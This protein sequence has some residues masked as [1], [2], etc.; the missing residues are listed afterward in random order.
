MRRSSMK[1]KVMNI[2]VLIALLTFALAPEAGGWGEGRAPVDIDRNI[3]KHIESLV[4]IGPRQAGTLN[5]GRAADYIA[6]QFRAMGIPVLIE[7]FAFESFEPSGVE[8]R[9]G[10]EK[11]APAGLGLDPY[12]GE[13][14]YEGAFVLLDPLTPFSW[15]SSEAV[16]GKAVVTAEEG[17]PSLHFRITALGPRFIIDLSPGDFD[18]IRE[19]KESELTLSVRGEL[20]KGTS[21][22]VIAHL[23]P[24]PP[25]V[26]III[27]AHLDAYRDCPGASDNASGV[28]ALLELARYMK[29]FENLERIG[30][31][32][33]AFGA[34]EVGILGSRRYVERHGDEL[35]HCS[36]A[37][38]IDDLGGGAPVHIERNGGQQALP[39]NPGV[40]LIPQTYQG[41][42]WEG[43][44][45]PWKLMPPPTL[46]AALG[47]SF[48]P[49]WLVDSI[50]KAVKELGIEVHFTQIQGSDQMSFAQAGIATSGITAPTGRGHT[51]DDRPDTVNIEK[52]RQ[53]VETAGRILLR[54]LDHLRPPSPDEPIGL[55]PGHE[56]LAHVRFLASDEL[57]GRRAG[58]PEG[59]IAA[60]YIAEHL[61]A[62]GVEAF[63]DAPEYFQDVVWQRKDG[64][65]GPAGDPVHAHNV[66][67]FIRG[68][69]ASRA[70]EYVLLMAH[71]D[72]LGA[73]SVDNV[74]TI[75]NGARDNAMG[76]AAVLTAAESLAA[77]PPARSI[78]VLATTAEEE[79]MIGS[80][81]FVEHPIVPLPR[82]VFV[83]NNDGAGVYEP[84]LWC[85][86]GLERTTAGPLAEAAGLAHGLATRPYPEKYQYL[87][88][89]GDAIVFADVGI[90]SLTVSP[91]FAEGQ[92]KRISKYIHTSA[93]R[94]DVDF[95]KDY[96]LRF[97]LAYIDLA[98]AIAKYKNLLFPSELNS[99]PWR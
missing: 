72:H 35:R 15:P 12:A 66:V 2:V 19:H 96:L 44:R 27:G 70:G 54:T 56:P 28:A 48:H 36:L 32:F 88:A 26:Q 90:P 37:L 99:R 41:R 46:F 77:T 81:F 80:R 42:A 16:A 13:L 6:G 79:G 49:A 53:C 7:S 21:R 4:A 51:Q 47:N 1:V 75:F 68:R 52:V 74:E 29:G 71:Y 98:R 43:L 69:D 57:R 89:E 87:F 65:A 73:R 30:L 11:I 82:I 84:D 17:D 18:R 50:D 22:N 33:I 93:D 86:G 59:D 39:L 8:L 14:G 40:G 23:G 55:R 97:C 78:L 95:D 58:S 83:L 34:E 10:T 62:A 61:R 31:T 9:I 5:E 20:I 38:V 94:V 67:G 3:S 76:V 45:Y 85:L 63:P 92:E 64:A 60:R 24:N 25:A 91:G